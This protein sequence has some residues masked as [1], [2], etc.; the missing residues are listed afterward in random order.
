VKKTKKAGFQIRE[1]SADKAY[2]SHDNLR[3][4]TKEGGT[5]YIAFKSDSV[6][7]DDKTDAW[8]RM[9]HYYSL[10]REEFLS[11]YH[12]RSNV[13][14]TFWMIKSKFGE[15]IRSKDKDAQVNEALCKILG[16]NLC[17]VIQSMFELGIEAE[18]W[19]EDQLS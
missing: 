8:Y 12:K 2:S 18:F 9:F 14:S 4:I 3:L 15:Q 1:A 6:A 7:G 19:R 16:H 17:V 13:E 10:H 5:P 11:H